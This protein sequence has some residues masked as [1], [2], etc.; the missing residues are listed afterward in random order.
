[1]FAFTWAQLKKMH[2]NNNE[3]KRC[4]VKFTRFL[5]VSC[6]CCVIF[7]KHST[8]ILKKKS[9]PKSIYRTMMM[10]NNYNYRDIGTKVECFSTERRFLFVVVGAVWIKQFSVCTF[11]AMM[12]AFLLQPP[13]F[14]LEMSM[15]EKLPQKHMTVC[16]WV[17][18]FKKKKMEWK[19]RSK[20]F[21]YSLNW[22]IYM[23]FFPLYS[24]NSFVDTFF[25]TFDLF[26]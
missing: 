5:F 6:V 4:D 17:S 9:I 7:I 25:Y 14:W 2:C 3:K 24:F 22:I 12:L 20:L 15:V 11:H 21:E 23:K 16:V 13:R 1:M 18:F 19:Q 8:Y 10:N 26:A